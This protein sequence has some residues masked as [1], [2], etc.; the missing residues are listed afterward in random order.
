MMSGACPPPAPSVWNGAPLER[1]DGVLD[2]PALVQRVGVDH[3]LHVEIV[4][5]RQTIVDRG[6]RGAPVL[7][8]L[9]RAGASLDHFL[10]RR[11]P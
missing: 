9:H 5:D 7:V 2:E 6:R 3:H 8:Q 1:R 4:G 11:G 10:E